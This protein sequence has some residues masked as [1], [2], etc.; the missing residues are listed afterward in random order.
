MRASRFRR[1]THSEIRQGFEA[2]PVLVSWTSDIP[3][4][5]AMAVDASTATRVP[6]PILPI[7]H[8]PPMPQIALPSARL[9]VLSAPNPCRVFSLPNA[10]LELQKNARRACFS[11]KIVALTDKSAASLM[12]VI[13]TFISTPVN[14]LAIQYSPIKAPANSSVKG[15]VGTEMAVSSSMILLP[16][17]LILH[18]MIPRARM[19]TM[20]AHRRLL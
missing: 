2:L 15:C 9:K 17:I 10:H 3:W 1:F 14:L 18:Q 13:Y 8:L 11:S 5:L 16:L 12:L 6:R 4:Q 19:T 7:I 20:S